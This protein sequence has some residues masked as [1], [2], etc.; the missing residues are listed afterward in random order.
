MCRRVHVCACV[1]VLACVSVCAYVCS[2]VCMHVW[3]WVRVDA[4]LGV[5]A[6]VACV[7]QRA[8]AFYV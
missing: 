1:G 4:R 2:S 7:C 3:G 8:P 6:R 5:D